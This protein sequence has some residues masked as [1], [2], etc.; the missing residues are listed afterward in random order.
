MRYI[1]LTGRLTRDAEFRESGG[2]GNGDK[3]YKLLKFS[4]ANNDNGKDKDPEFF[5]VIAWENLATWANDYM[6]KGKKVIVMGVPHNQRYKKE[7]ENRTHF[8][9]VA[10]RIEFID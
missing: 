2:D 6:K 9:V 10:E 7:N 8:Q 5:D 1:V 4:I 3:K